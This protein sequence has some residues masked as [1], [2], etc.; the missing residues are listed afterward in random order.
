MGIIAGPQE[1]ARGVETAACKRRRG[2]S[3][4]NRRYVRVLAFAVLAA[5][6]TAVGVAAP[7]GFPPAT[8]VEDWIADIRLAS[9]TP[10]EPQREDIVVLAIDEAT[11]AKTNYR[12]PVDRE[13][14]AGRVRAL[15]GE[16]SNTM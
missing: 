6:L 16:I 11:L 3:L 9:L 8:L 5:A 13:D 7:R 2:A 10:V 12:S 14:L 1:S 4:L 15:S